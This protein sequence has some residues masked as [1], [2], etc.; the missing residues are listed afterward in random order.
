MPATF[1]V[2]RCGK[3]T[4][5]DG[6]V[7]ELAGDA[8]TMGRAASCAVKTD[9]DVV[10]RLHAKLRLVDESWMIVDLE[11]ANGTFVNARR[12][13]RAELRAGD[14]LMLGEGGPVYE[15][16]ALEGGRGGTDLESTR[17]LRVASRKRRPEKR[18]PP[19]D[20]PPPVH[21]PV[22]PDPEPPPA[23]EPRPQ[24]KPRPKPRPEP[25]A[26]PTPGEKRKRIHV[27]F[28]ALAGI[29]FGV[30]LGREMLGEGFPYAEFGAPG[31]WAVRFVPAA[32]P[33]VALCGA[34]A[35]YWMLVGV[36]LRRPIKR[37]WLLALLGAG[38][39]A[40]LYGPGLFAEEEEAPTTRLE[41]LARSADRLRRRA[42]AVRDA[43]AAIAGT[44][45]AFAAI[46][47]R[48][49]E[50]EANA[51]DLPR[52]EVDARLD[53]LERDFEMRALMVQAT[54]EVV[55]E[56][57]DEIAEELS[58]LRQELRK[59][60]EE[61]GDDP[62]LAEVEDALAQIEPPE[63]PSAAA[64]TEALEGAR[65]RFAARVAKLRGG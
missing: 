38:H 61:A 26:G 6:E 50:L 17:F 3:R 52:A 30:L 7:L 40:A 64:Q 1:V 39:A 14:K 8:F 19:G 62:R 53:A 46:L 44:E 4:E 20:S 43:P 27:P 13:E 9:V 54:K 60:R 22:E 65:K 59:L 12:V 45:R 16:V 5:R 29:V 15:V 58:A 2:L 56:D 28:L 21:V 36:A 32:P 23:P 57:P 37:F 63:P 31:A 11:S 51:A 47:A 55:E 18:T 41:D 25:V 48:L 34:L 33:V 42:L 49:G 24:S 35:L 10:S